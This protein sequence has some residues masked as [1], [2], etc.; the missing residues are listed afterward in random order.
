MLGV[1]LRMTILPDQ[2]QL[3]KTLFANAKYLCF[4]TVVLIFLAE[5]FV[6][7]LLS[8]FPPFSNVAEA[9]I[10]A[11]LLSVIV[12]PFLHFC[13]YRPMR[14]H[15]VKQKSIEKERLELIRQ[16]RQS[17]DEVK[18]L[19]GIIPICASCKMIR[20]DRGY[21]QQVDE[22]VKDRS[23]ATFSHSV[24]PCCAERLYPELT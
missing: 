4:M 2:D 17:L 21:W 18:V 11:L 10:D 1:E 12:F 22:Y 19:R 14:L 23:E 16:L 15:I 8:Y 7:M 9:F 5:A 24:C 6:M 13:I 3:E 20:D